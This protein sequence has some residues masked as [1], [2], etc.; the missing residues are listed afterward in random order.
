MKISSF[1]VVPLLVLL[2]T[3]CRAEQDFYGIQMKNELWAK[4]LV[5]GEVS[6][7]NPEDLRQGPI[8]NHAL[9]AEASLKPVGDE[10]IDFRVNVI[11]DTALVISSDYRYRD[12]FIYTKHGYRYP[13][14]DTEDGSHFDSIEP[15]S[16]V[17]FTPS[18]GNLRIQNGDVSMIGC[19]FDLGKTEIFL[20][21]WSKKEKINHL[22]SP[23][24]LPE[25]AAS[26]PQLSRKANSAT[27]ASS[28]KVSPNTNNSKS[29]EI[30]KTTP[31]NLLEW[32]GFN[33]PQKRQATTAA[34]VATAVRPPPSSR[35]R[36]DEAIKKFVY[37]SSSEKAPLATPTV[38][39]ETFNKLS[40]PIETK[41]EASVID[42]NKNYN[43]ITLNLGTRDGLRQNATLTILRNGKTV[44]KAKVKRLRETVA[45][46]VLLPGTIQAEVRP[47]DNIS[48]V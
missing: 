10:H 41:N 14:I 32:L 42:Y 33:S 3:T 16:S 12:F 45:A 23:A 46:A 28:P 30:K 11:N 7:P 18:L 29:K 25:E 22:V 35:K 5:L 36:V 37:T 4:N 47:G 40:V 21:P 34:Q 38:A 44:A 39:K 31:H 19:S 48:L 17:T 2:S 27:R 6:N 13:L 43:F 15:K 8:L 20:F 9:H 26:V 24:P 1:H